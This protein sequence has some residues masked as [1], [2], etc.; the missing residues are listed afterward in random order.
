MTT[1]FILFEQFSLQYGRPQANTTTFDL[2]E[3]ICEKAILDYPNASI[4]QLIN[5]ATPLV[6]ALY[7]L[8]NLPTADHPNFSNWLNKDDNE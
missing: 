5:S 7:T 6:K 1:K 4:E 3:R 8:P 2:L